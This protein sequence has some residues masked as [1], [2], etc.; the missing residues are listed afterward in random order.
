[1][2]EEDKFGADFSTRG[3]DVTVEHP[4]EDGTELRN[5]AH[6]TA[7][8]AAHPNTVDD[9]AAPDS[10]DEAVLD[11]ADRALKAVGIDVTAVPIERN[12]LFAFLL[13]EARGLDST[14]ELVQ[15]ID[16]NPAIAD[17]LGMRDLP[18]D[19]TFYRRARVLAAANLQK[20]LTNASEEAVHAV[21]RNS[22]SVPQSVLDHWGLDPTSTIWDYPVS[23][24]TRR[25]AIRN[26]VK[27]LLDDAT[28]AL[29]FDRAANAS[30]SLT[31]YIGILAHSALQNIG[32]TTAPTTLAWQYDPNQVPTGDCLLKHIQSNDLGLEDIETQFIQANAA[33]L[34][35]CAEL[36][37]FDEPLD[38]AFDMT[39]I[40]WWGLPQDATVGTYN[41]G[42]DSTPDWKFGLLTAINKDA[43]LCFGVKLAKSKDLYDSVIDDLLAAATTHAQINHLFADKEFYNGKVIDV[44]RKHIGDGWV[45]KAQNKQP[46]KDFIGNIPKGQV[47]IKRGIDA[48]SATPSPNG[49]AIPDDLDGQQTL[50]EY[51]DSTT[52]VEARGR[53]STHTAYLT[54]IDDEEEGL[55]LIRSRYNDRWSIETAIRQFKHDYL[56]VCATSNPKVRVYC[57]NIAV[58]FFN[59]HAL[60]NRALSPQYN[61]PLTLTSQELLTAVRD[62][63]FSDGGN[64]TK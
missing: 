44:L 5:R 53:I 37:M 27:L 12:Y 16:D 59:W 34:Q 55:E 26:W 47:G 31:E 45:I 3:T 64:T 48:T 41:P 56:P 33:V 42:T 36:G 29:T 50:A 39:S 18:S 21:C 32:I 49:F 61:L 17:R 63:A 7:Q 57:A 30:Y 14:L 23:A 10:F 46:V 28:G 38:L 54:D 52:Q 15:Y 43:R 1:M 22:I 60:I 6:I 11:V 25:Q 9:T 58:L 35:R 19:S 51:T 20:A 62:V 4:V 13:R 2:N 8:L 40:T 24:E